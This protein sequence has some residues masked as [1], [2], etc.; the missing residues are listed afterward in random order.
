MDEIKKIRCNCCGRELK[1]ENGLLAEDL[2]EGRKDW[3]YFS[4]KDL[5]VHHF[6]LCEECYDAITGQFV[7]PVEK[8][9]KKEIL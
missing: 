8:M 4:R 1:M 7:I 6:Y 9:D 3:G 5:E 2:F